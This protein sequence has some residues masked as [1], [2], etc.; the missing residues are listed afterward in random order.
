MIGLFV[1]VLTQ[2]IA[3]AMGIFFLFFLLRALLRRQWLAAAVFI[4]LAAG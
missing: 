4:L 2:S 3:I 1:S